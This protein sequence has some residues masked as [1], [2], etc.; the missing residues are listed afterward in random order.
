MSQSRMQGYVGS[1]L[2]RYNQIF[3]HRCGL[4]FIACLAVLLTS[5][6]STSRLYF[7]P[8][9]QWIRT[10]AVYG[11]EYQDVWL[12]SVDGTSV[13][14]WWIPAQTGSDLGAE[15]NAKQPSTNILYL[16][17]NA[18][19][20]SSHIASVAW[21]SK[22]GYG[23]LALDYRGFGASE[24]R[25]LMPDVL[26]DVEAAASWLVAHQPD[27]EL[28]VLGQSMG[29][30]LAVD[31][32]A[33]SQHRYGVDVIVLESPFASFGDAARDAVT[34]SW[35]GWLL[36]PFTWLVPSQ[37]DPEKHAP[38]IE[39]PVLLIHSRD[40]QVINIQQG[41]RVFAALGR[42]SENDSHHSNISV[43]C[44]REVNGPHIAAFSSAD[45]RRAVEEFLRS[46]SCSSLP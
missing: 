9:S 34:S 35:L 6:A 13:H 4:G 3:K 5:C 7:Y 21:L 11:L 32:V 8:K 19:N 27:S 18:Q 15:A 2:C 1:A 17:G 42:A 26:Q 14:A 29:A 41:R 25:P 23:L 31:F 20:I 24:G 39:V 28:V 37:W 16:H 38:N 36:W 10:P 45:N 30:S 43:H 12:K 33:Q 22:A 46:K 44:W 40:D